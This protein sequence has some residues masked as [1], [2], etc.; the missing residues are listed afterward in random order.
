ME[1]TKELL[2]K[3]CPTSRDVVV[4]GVSK[5]LTKFSD[6]YDVNTKL[7]MAHF[8]AQAAHESGH[9]RTLEEYAS[10][11][12]YD[13]RTDLGN[14]PAVDGDGRRYKGRGIFQV[15]GKANYK[16]YGDLIG[17]D[18]V[19]NPEI[20]SH[21]D[22]SVKTALEYWRS[23]KLNAKADLDDIVEITKAI[24][25]GKNGLVERITYL[26]KAKKLLGVSS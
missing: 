3:L 16:K 13:T 26:E 22:I 5:Y 24:N 19:A 20:A 2:F 9:F 1:V 15:T 10:G 14:T 25:G 23:H 7:R 18:L 11:D 17:V 4:E 8:L 21:A 6:F 12:A